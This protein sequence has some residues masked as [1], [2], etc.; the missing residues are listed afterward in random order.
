M[1]K[2]SLDQEY[3]QHAKKVDKYVN[4][5]N[6]SAKNTTNGVVYNDDKEHACEC[7]QGSGRKKAEI[8]SLIVKHIPKSK[9]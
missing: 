9:N 7:A 5:C 8:V 1:T 3:N 2:F 4:P 6:L